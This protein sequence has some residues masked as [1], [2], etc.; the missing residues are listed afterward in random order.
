MQTGK[1]G[2]QMMMLKNEVEEYGFY[3]VMRRLT[4]I[5]YHAV[6]VS[7]IPMTSE[8]IKEMQRASKDF[9]M[10]IAAMSCGLADLSPEIKYPGDTLENNFDKIVADCH[11]V[12]C[13]IL[14][15]GMLPLTKATTIEDM[16]EVVDELEEYASR[17]KEHG[18]DLYYHPHNFEFVLWN[19]KPVLTHM[20]ERT[21]QLG[22]EL[23][24]HWIWRG[25]FDPAQ[26]IQSF[27][28]R[29]RALHL[30]DYRIGLIE[31]EE[32]FTRIGYDFFGRIE[33]FA[34]VGEGT[35]DIPEI[36]EAGFSSGCDYFFVEQD[37]TYGRD[38]YDCLQNSYGNLI[39]MG[40]EELF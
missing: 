2:V 39:Q 32:I 26:Y 35:I 9:D 12:D 16:L 15:V 27:K 4:E 38:V 24:S 1:I 7:Q 37:D 34:E 33:Q 18:I 36:V 19:K 21:S 6:E 25:G 23:D 40:Y 8:N 13:T 28:G 11:A 20:K 14:R 30:K 10:D 22:F 5:G 29:I 31:D 17:L 3:E